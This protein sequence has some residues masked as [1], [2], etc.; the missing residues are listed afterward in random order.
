MTPTPLDAIS[1]LLD[2]ADHVA[3]VTGIALAV[4]GG[5][6]SMALLAASSALAATE[7]RLAE[8]WV[9]HVD[10]D[11]RPGSQ[12]EAELV[13]REARRLGMKARVIALDEN[14]PGRGSLEG[15]ARARRY[16]ALEAA[17]LE[18]GLD[19]VL[20]AHHREDQAET[21]GLAL[22]RGAHALGLQGM[23]PLRPLDR[24]GLRLGRP[25]LEI[26]RDELDRHR[27]AEGLEAADDETNRD[28][29]HRRNLLRHL[30]LAQEGRLDADRLLALSAR[31]GAL[32]AR[33]R[34]WAEA[35][36][37]VRGLET[38]GGLGSRSAS[39]DDRGLAGLPEEA[40]RGLLRALLRLIGRAEIMPSAAAIAGLSAPQAVVELARDCHARRG[41]G[42]LRVEAKRS[43][44]PYERR[45]LVL[46]AEAITLPGGGR[47]RAGRAAL[48]DSGRSRRQS[49]PLAEVAGPLVLRG[50]RAGERMQPF[51][52]Q[53]TKS[54]TEI[55]REAGVPAEERGARPVVA[56]DL[57]VLWVPGLRASERCRLG[58]GTGAA[59]VLELFD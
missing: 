5:R 34:A 50:A 4:S 46:E 45:R 24:T 37:A 28:L 39:I 14:P 1:R 44:P 11:L 40:A 33:L 2:L 32:E 9:L 17:M 15:W 7:P 58:P 3:P 51:G 18:L 53:G 35:E 36:V 47:L 56:D 20:T 38:G 22:M 6:D 13:R 59:I 8:A 23:A 54:L 30:I 12:L 29:G 19:L 25:F 16:G 43:C 57:G 26:G 55:F 27:L 10:H 42:R 48:D 21:V 31:A 41:D 49:L 52:M